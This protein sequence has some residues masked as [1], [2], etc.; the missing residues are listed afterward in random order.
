MQFCLLICRPTGGLSFFP[1]PVYVGPSNA[2]NICSGRRFFFFLSFK[3]CSVLQLSGQAGGCISPPT[4]C[5]LD[6]T[7]SVLSDQFF[8]YPPYVLHY[9]LSYISRLL[10]IIFIIL[11]IFIVFL[12]CFKQSYCFFVFSSLFINF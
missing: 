12:F 6:K 2:L 10:A 4:R 7:L 11:V 3:I 8:F 5:H 1:S 9:L